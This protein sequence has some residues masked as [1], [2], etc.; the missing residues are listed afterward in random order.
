[1][2]TQC[3]Q[4]SLQGIVKR[5]DA[6]YSHENVCHHRSEHVFHHA[7]QTQVHEIIST[8]LIQIAV[9]Q[10]AQSTRLWLAMHVSLTVLVALH[11]LDTGT[12]A[13]VSMLLSV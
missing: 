8:N 2:Y 12:L 3:L 7:S 1:M 5:L 13:A 10:C 6:R 9:G 11:R 4:Q